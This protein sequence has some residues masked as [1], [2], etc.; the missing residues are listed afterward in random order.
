VDFSIFSERLFR[1]DGSLM[2]FNDRGQ[3]PNPFRDP[4]DPS[5]GTVDCHPNVRGDFD[6]D[7]HADD[8]CYKVEG[9]TP[10]PVG[11]L[12]VQGGKIDLSGLTV[13]VM[14]RV[15]F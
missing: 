1:K 9:D 12:V 15:W 5:Q 4:N 13:N 6:H 2:F 8:L 11:I 3:F 14:M 7:G 10:D